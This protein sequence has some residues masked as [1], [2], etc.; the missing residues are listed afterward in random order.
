MPSAKRGTKR[1]KRPSKKKGAGSK[2]I[3]DHALMKALSHRLR[4]RIF[5]ILNER[6]AS[7][8]GL[9]KEL[10]EGLSQVSYHF[11]ELKKLGLIE[12]E[13]EVPRRGAVEHFY[14]AVRR[15]VVPKDAWQHLPPSLKSGLS[16]EIMGQS[17]EDVEASMEAGIFDDP[18]SHASWSPLIVDREGM[19]CVDELANECLER[20][21]KIQA[22]S[23]GR[24]MKKGEE[25]FSL[26]VVLASFLSTRSPEESK[27]AA[28]TKQR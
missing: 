23:T 16:A 21:F 6:S 2:D 18:D 17:Y 15:V 5:V 13:K 11:T 28:A 24:L 1:G 27:R 20:L 25:G 19:K 3:V 4:T 26:T 7:P 9:S 22:D 14:R 8:N 12:L 10:R